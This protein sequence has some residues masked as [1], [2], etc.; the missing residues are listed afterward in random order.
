[1]EKLGLIAGTGFADWLTEG[2][3]HTVSTPYGN[4]SAAIT[5]RRLNNYQVFYL[6]R[7]G[8]P[9]QLAP[10][11]VNYRANIHALHSLGIKQVVAV[12]VVGSIRT[13]W[14]SGSLIIPDQIIDYTW[15][16]EHTFFHT[17]DRADQPIEHIDF[18]QPYSEPLR[19]LLLNAGDMAGLPVFAGGCYA[20]TQGPRLES[21]AEVQRI[22]RDGGDMIGMTG[23]PE[24]SLAR[25]RNMQ[26]AS[27]CLVSNLAAGVA[28]TELSIEEIMSNVQA[29]TQ[30]VKS[31]LD[32]FANI[33]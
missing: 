25:E 27:I 28:G 10:H 26:F 30:Q 33:D 20:A 7:H 8:N 31:L 19:Q 9:H 16:R 1:M 6:P 22:N 17:I 11:A 24:A 32:Q 2:Q 4:P 15:G 12:N 18:T 21:A 13:E 23:M 29:G 3:Q 5:A 14:P